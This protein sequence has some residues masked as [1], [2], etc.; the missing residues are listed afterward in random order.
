MRLVEKPKDPPS[1]LALVGVYMFTPAIFDAARAIEPS[2]R[3]ELE[4]TDAI[5]ALIDDGR[6]VESHVVGGWWKD[7][8]QL[9]DMLEANRLVLE[10]V[11][12]R[13]EGDADEASRV[14][15]RVVVEAG[16]RLER[17][18]VR[19]PAV[20]G[21][22]RGSSTPTS[23]PT[24]RSAAD[25][26]VVG[27]EVEHSILLAGAR[28]RDLQ[29]RMEASLLGRNVNL[30]RGDE[31]PKT[32]RM[33]VGDNSEISDPV[34]VLVTGAGG[35]LGR[36]VVAAGGAAATTVV[37]LDARRARRHR[38]RRRSSEAIA[39]LR[40]RR[41]HQLRRLDRRRRRRGRRAGRDAGQRHR[42]RAASR[43]RGGARL[44][45]SSTSPATTSSTAPRARPTS[46]PTCPAAISAYGRSKLAG[47]TAIAIAN[48][49]HFIVRS[50]WLFGAGGPNFVETMLRLGGRAGR[51]A[52]R[53]RPGRL[54]RPTPAHLAAALATLVEGEDYGIHHIAAAGQCSWFEFAQEIFDQEGIECRVMAATTEMLGRPAPRPRLLGARQRASGPDRAAGLAGRAAPSTSPPAA[55]GPPP[56]A[57]CDERARHRRRR[58]HRLH[59]RPPP[60]RRTTRGSRSGCSTSSPTRAGAR[61][62]RGS[63]RAAASWSSATSP[64]ATRPAAAL[65]GCDAI[66]NFAAESHV[67]RSIEAP[68]EF[69]QTDVYRHLRPARGG[70]RRRRSATCRSRPTRSTARSRRARSPSPRR[71]TRP[72]R[73]RP[74]RRAATC[75]S[76]P[77]S[78]PTAPTR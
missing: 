25:V 64:T 45:A 74:R 52:R 62:S 69:I 13:L 18:V 71:S 35:M 43:R 16:A 56:E 51:G 3:G 26:E 75:W 22:A 78:A 24:P 53:L 37:G 20:I 10:D 5:Q 72:R 36:D 68:G 70:P 9:A 6:R 8:G 44:Q 12:T 31:M 61:T 65:E 60:A 27:S 7:T 46:S 63:T 76:A 34:R 47:E 57:P 17:S 19:G 66:V 29:T 33:I 14:E 49:R 11:E 73:T 40:P 54:A 30:S 21:A 58:V 59:L 48:P 23:V 42:R 77:S 55:R 41:G 67:D 28:V 38:R 15:G 39:A 4:I 50:S 1:D 32:L 2:W